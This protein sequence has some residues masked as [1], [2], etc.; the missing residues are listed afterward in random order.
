MKSEVLLMANT[1]VN[2]P[3]INY[4]NSHRYNILTFIK[5][6]PNLKTQ[7]KVFSARNL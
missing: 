7:I 3:L 2:I 4:N 5:K 6:I 1:T